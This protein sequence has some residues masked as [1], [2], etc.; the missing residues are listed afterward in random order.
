M[1][2][3]LHYAIAVAV[4]GGFTGA[5]VS[6]GEHVLL[7]IGLSCAYWAAMYMPMLIGD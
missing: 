4:T 2:K 7:C 6:M 1:K 3:Y 5:L